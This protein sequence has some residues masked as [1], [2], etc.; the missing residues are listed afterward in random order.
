VEKQFKSQ[1]EK[2]KNTFGCSLL[3]HPFYVSENRIILRVMLMLKPFAFG[4]FMSYAMV[5]LFEP[6][7]QEF[8]LGLE[9]SH[10]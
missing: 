5:W 7:Q 9:I 2:Q 8:T 3:L 1:L 4:M 10:S 6:S